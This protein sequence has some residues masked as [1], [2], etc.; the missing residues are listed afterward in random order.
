MNHLVNTFNIF[1][2]RQA[3]LALALG[4]LL[5][6]PFWV[7]DLD[8]SFSSNHFE[9]K[10]GWHKADEPLWQFIYLYTSVPAVILGIAAFISISLS[11]SRES[12]VKWRKPAI[13]FILTL[14]IGPGILVNLIFKDNW[15]RPRPRDIEP[16]GGKEK[17]HMVWEKGADRR[18]KSFPCGH[19]SMGFVLAAPFFF[20]Y[21]KRKILAFL[22]AAI[23]IV[24][25]LLV[26]YTRI[27]AGGHFLSDVLWSGVMVWLA[28]V[29]AGLIIR[30]EVPIGQSNAIK[31][32]SKLVSIGVGIFVPILLFFALIATPY[33]ERWK[34]VRSPEQM[35]EENVRQLLIAM[36]TAT[37]DLF[38]GDSLIIASEINGF[39]LPTSK[40]LPKW[41]P[42]DTA[43]YRF[44]YAGI[45]TDIS[46]D[47]KLTLPVNSSMKIKVEVANGDVYLNFPDAVDYATFDLSIESGDLYV[48]SR[49]DLPTFEIS[50]NEREVDY[51]MIKSDLIIN[52]SVIRLG[53]KPGIKINLFQ[54]K[55]KIFIIPCE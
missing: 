49:N 29:I 28:A 40:Y 26:G 3:L 32:K 54:E 19:C 24:S 52:R 35:E 34:F 55:G 46:N 14:I 39:G 45:F 51:P 42:E 16:F 33:K 37:T 15:G 20:F 8:V 1:W 12:W 31:K 38:M 18:F 5:T 22:F 25:G 30:P 48:L 13:H 41:Y 53:K 50:H 47:T 7:S 43:L 2:V 4:I 23:G 21:R 17:Y 27:L 36:G 9:V 44:H 10:N 11:Y 6:V